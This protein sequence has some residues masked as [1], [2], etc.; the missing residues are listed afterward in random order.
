MARRGAF[1]YGVC[2][3]VQGGQPHCLDLTTAQAGLLALEMALSLFR[4][5][6]GTWLIEHPAGKGSFWSWETG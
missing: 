5:L 2:L 3:R 1:T 4:P 6:P